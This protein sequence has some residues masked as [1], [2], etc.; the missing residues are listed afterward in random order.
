MLPFGWP[1]LVD[2]GVMAASPGGLGLWQQVAGCVP[3]PDPRFLALLVQDHQLLHVTQQVAQRAVAV[4][5]QIQEPAMV[6]VEEPPEIPQGGA[7]RVA[8]QQPH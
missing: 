2:P 4:P 7:P 8:Q 5:G 6:L 3:A 1:L